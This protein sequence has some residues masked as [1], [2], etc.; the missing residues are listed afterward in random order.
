MWFIGVHIGVGAAPGSAQ[1]ERLKDV[2]EAACNEAAGCLGDSVD[3]AEGDVEGKVI[4][5]AETA[6]TLLEASGAV[7]AGKGSNRDEDST[8][9]GDAT[10][11]TSNGSLGCVCSTESTHPI[12]EA[13]S[14]A[15]KN[16]FPDA[17]PSPVMV[18]GGLAKEKKEEKTEPR[19][20][21]GESDTV[22]VVIGCDDVYVS[23]VSSGGFAG[24]VRGRVG[25]AGMPGAGAWA[26]E[27]GAVAL[28]GRGEDAM[29]ELL[30]AR[31]SFEADVQGQRD[32][33]A[34][35]IAK[36][37]SPCGGIILKGKD[38]F[39]L[40]AFY[41]TQ[42]FGVAYRSSCGKHSEHILKRD[43]LRPAEWCAIPEHHSF[44]V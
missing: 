44:R 21:R 1:G 27:G 2:M 8:Q 14:L 31:L 33:I 25:E 35:F 39:D 22:G 18:S 26:C 28:S 6:L 11:I 10:I 24:K 16:A 13:A 38:S 23:A 29:K 30:A 7:N 17:S 32:R 12:K 15:R 3:R 9:R 42:A 5:A 37:Q 19:L 36:H 34:A 4:T 20:D 43:G 41:N 40:S